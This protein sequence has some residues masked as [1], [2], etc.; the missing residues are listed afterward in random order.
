MDKSQVPLSR[1]VVVS[2]F[3]VLQTVFVP[4]DKKPKMGAELP[5]LVLSLDPKEGDL[6]KFL[7]M[8]IDAEN[9][10]NILLKEFRTHFGPIKRKILEDSLANL[11][12]EELDDSPFIANTGTFSDMLTTPLNSKP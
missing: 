10:K 2:N 9:P 6:K 4:K 5:R 3:K 8:N 11:P 12:T 1:N 7:G